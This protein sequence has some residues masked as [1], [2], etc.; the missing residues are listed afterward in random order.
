[1]LNPI[2]QRFPFDTGR[3]ALV[4]LLAT[5]VVLSCVTKHPPSVPQVG[6][7]T[8]GWPGDTLEFTFCAASPTGAPIFYRISWGDTSQQYIS[9]LTGSEQPLTK[10]HVYA[11]TGDYAL[12][13]Q[14]ATSG[15]SESD[16]SQPV[17]VHVSYWVPDPPSTPEGPALLPTETICQ[18]S[19]RGYHPVGDSVA[20]QFR[21]GDSL[22]K[23]SEPT[24]ADRGY[25]EDHAFTQPCT[26]L[27]AAR[28]K[29]QHGNVTT[30]SEPLEVVA[31]GGSR[32]GGPPTTV[33]LG[34]ANSGLGVLVCWNQPSEGKPDKYLVYFRSLDESTYSVV[35]DTTDLSYIHNP[36]GLTG[37]YKVAAVFWTQSY[38]STCEP[39]TVPIATDTTTIA[40]L[41]TSGN[42]GYGWSRTSG[43]G[44][45][46]SMIEKSNAP[47]VD[48]YIT[49][50]SVGSRRFP[51][52][53]ASPSL[54]PN[55]PS[56]RVE[57]SSSWKSTWF[58]PPLT[59]AIETL[60]AQGYERSTR[61]TR[62]P[63]VVG[64]HTQDGYS[65]LIEVT[66]VNAGAASIRAVTWFQK[67]RGLRLVR[68]WCNPVPLPRTSFSRSPGRKV[69]N[70]G[71]DPVVHELLDL[72][73]LSASD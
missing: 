67:V 39:S 49:D 18:Y 28:A 24:I 17:M 6:G 55:D 15:S 44:Q 48:F 13:A 9:G 72:K 37:S 62:T 33:Q 41:D 60:P 40:E 71:T 36:H 52:E 7:A 50:S 68:Y 46:Y 3:R 57:P 30:W 20:F 34:S 29:D 54:A 2:R 25:T 31:Y 69:G 63:T 19:T 16:W 14:A 56:G 32:P 22:G 59:G 65:A 64:C 23:W 27:V 1:M 38:F 47:F 66:E 58:T 8:C 12:C 4:V 26:L 51:Y 10:V 45:T 73:P 21:W 43:S 61:I 5:T 35:G 42:S 53:T 70:V 11:D